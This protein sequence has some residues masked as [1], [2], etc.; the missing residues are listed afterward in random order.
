MSYNFIQRNDEKHEQLVKSFLETV[1][2]IIVNNL[3]LIHL[4][5]NGMNL[6][7]HLLSLIPKVKESR[8][9]N[10]VHMSD[11]DVPQE[12]IK[13]AYDKM[14]LSEL[15]KCYFQNSSE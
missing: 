1:G 9:L 13:L 8:S 3:R 11:N 2:M 15:Y 5:I 7:P 10:S 6:G 14:G 12:Y 4:N